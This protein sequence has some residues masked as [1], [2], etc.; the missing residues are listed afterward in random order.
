MDKEQ[1]RAS[2]NHNGGTLEVVAR[3]ENES[4]RDRGRA[5]QTQS[6][7]RPAQGSARR[8]NT[9]LYGR[10]EGRAVRP[11]GWKR[12]SSEGRFRVLHRSWSAGRCGGRFQGRGLLGSQTTRGSAQDAWRLSFALNGSSRSSPAAKAN[13]LE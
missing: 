13:G 1:S 10:R 9:F 8:S 2:K 11:G 3:D 6:P 7:C 12:V 5:C 4:G